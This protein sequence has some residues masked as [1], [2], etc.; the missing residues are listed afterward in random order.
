MDFNFRFRGETG[1]LYSIDSGRDLN[2]GQA[3]GDRARRSRAQYEAGA[4]FWNLD[5]TLTKGV[6]LGLEVGLRRG[7]RRSRP[8]RQSRLVH[9][10]L[11]RGARGHEPGLRP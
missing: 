4:G 6:R 2:G 11:E 8:G 9:R 3:T 1:D 5:M 10:R 7:R